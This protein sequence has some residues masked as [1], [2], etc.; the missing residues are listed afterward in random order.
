MYRLPGIGFPRIRDKNGAVFIV[1]LCLKQK[2]Q[3]FRVF[4]GVKGRFRI[5][6]IGPDLAGMDADDV[7]FRIV[8]EIIVQ[9][10]GKHI[11]VCM[12]T[13]TSAAASPSAVNFTR[14][15]EASFPARM[16]ARARPRKVFRVGVVYSV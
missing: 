2:P 5:V 6:R 7:E 8:F 16:I 1:P 11:Q 10:H 4:I 15:A 12:V 13:L 9:R 14:S 3:R